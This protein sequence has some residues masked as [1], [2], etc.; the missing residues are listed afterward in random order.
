MTKRFKK[1][2]TYLKGLNDKDIIFDKNF[3]SDSENDFFLIN[4]QIPNFY[5]S[6]TETAQVT[7]LQDKFYNEIKFP[8]YDDLDDFSLLI[9]K[10]KKSIF[11]K[12][13][14]E[15]ILFGS[16]ILEVGCGTGQ[17][18]N[19]LSRYKRKIFGVDLSESSLI[20]GDDFRIKSDIENVYFV[21]MNLFKLLFN[22]NYF[23]YII[24]IGCLHH[25]Q[26]PKKAFFSIEKKLKKGGFLV[27]GL[28]HKY[29]RIYTKIRKRIFSLL[30]EK[31][32]F[33]DK[34]LRDKNISYEKRLTWYRDQY[35]SPH[36]ISYTIK[37]VL[38]WFKEKNLKIT[39]IL[40]LDD[41]NENSDLFKSNNNKIKN[42]SLKEMMLALNI[43]H[44]SEGGLFTI[45]AEK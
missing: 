18:S 35:K 42:F 24:S 20:M 33:L 41:L 31:A 19:F 36:E 29:G 34:Y 25:T 45:I 22:D 27:L 10:A 32:F 37:E 9:D 38:E 40:P 3:F 39:K 4:N 16:K 30:G 28:Y 1:L 8:N 6:D 26:D 12:L 15:Q 7:S 43:S 14:D 21:K 5:I 44:A 13:L 23:D 17:L 2:S 11:A